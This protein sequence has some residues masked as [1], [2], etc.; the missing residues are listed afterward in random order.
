[1]AVIEQVRDDAEIW[2]SHTRAQ[3]HPW[4][5]LSSQR[6]GQDTVTRRSAGLPPGFTRE[7]FRVDYGGGEPG[8]MEHIAARVHR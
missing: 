3:V 4:I 5:S 2:R 1:M 6:T 7:S 8:D